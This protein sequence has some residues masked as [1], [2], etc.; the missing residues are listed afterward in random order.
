[1]ANGK[2]VKFFLLAFICLELL[3]LE[4]L[5]KYIFINKVP[6][7]GFYF[8]PQFAQIIYTPNQNIAFSLPLPQVFIIV[9]VIIIII[10]LSYIWWH[11]FLKGNL[12]ELTAISIVILGAFSNLI[13]RLVFGYVIDYIKIWIWPVFNLADA[14]IVLGIFIYILSEFKKPKVKL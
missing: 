2:L 9:I 10:V 12:W 8:I 6:S 7:E 13:D 11:I 4:S 5:I 14:M 1:M 3:I